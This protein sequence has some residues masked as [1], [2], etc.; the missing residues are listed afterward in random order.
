MSS[1]STG[2]YCVLYRVLPCTPR[3]PHG[4]PL[5]EA[6]TC[7]AAPVFIWELGRPRRREAEGTGCGGQHSQGASCVSISGLP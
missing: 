2:T 4:G 6:P 1:G 5:S 3:S 7:Q